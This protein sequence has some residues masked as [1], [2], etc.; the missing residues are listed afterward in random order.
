MV[1]IQ[2]KHLTKIYRWY[3]RR[4]DLFKEVLSLNRKPYHEQRLALDD[5]SF[6]VGTG[7]SIGVMGRNG[8][9]KS[10]LLKLLAGLS[11]PTSGSFEVNG[12]V[13]ALLELGTGFHPDYSGIDN[14]RINGVLLGLSRRETELKLPAIV[15]FAELADVIRQPLRTYS[16][17]MQA[18]L[19]FAIATA[20]QPD[21]L[22]I[23]EVLAVGDAYFVNKCI[24]YLQRFI[25]NGGTVLVVSH[26]SFL[27]GRL[28]HKILW[29]ENGALRQFDTAPAVCR[30]YDLYVRGLESA[31]QEQAGRPAGGHR[32]GSGEIHIQSVHLLDWKGNSER[33]YF[34]G[35]RMVV[36]IHYETAGRYENPSVYLLVTRQDGVLVTSCFSG[37]EPIDLGVF[38]GAGFVDVTFDPLLLGDGDY[39]LSAGI[40]PHKQGPESIYRLDPFD[41]HERACEF[42]IKR[43]IRPLQTVF[44][45]PVMWFHKD[46]R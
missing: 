43:P 4:A 44:D 20:L 41:Y 34:C 45:H 1:V 30:A 25:S 9:G 10:T 32:W 38:Q 35:E 6:E 29:L 12:K 23:D 8:A 39:W 24:Q 26:N 36:R 18:R 7:E 17:G 13:A 19:A 42:T 28:C 22:L 15:E 27:L 33:A 3:A 40:F 5:V 31:R 37:E 2:A 11:A 16:T 14:I 46:A 21:L